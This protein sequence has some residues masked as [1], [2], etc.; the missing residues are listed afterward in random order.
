[1][2]EKQVVALKRRLTEK[3]LKDI[4]AID[5]VLALLH[6]E[7]TGSLGLPE[8]SS[9]AA[10]NGHKGPRVRGVLKAVKQGSAGLPETFTRDKIFERLQ[11]THP[12]LAAKVQKRSFLNTVK[13][14]IDT[15][16]FAIIEE[17]TSGKPATLKRGPKWH[18]EVIKVG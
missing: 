17:G 18:E 10:S 6:E 7:P 5:R 14:L 1:M 13:D 16:Y 8:L 11:E 2:N 4:E 12:D 3:H 15:D 9:I